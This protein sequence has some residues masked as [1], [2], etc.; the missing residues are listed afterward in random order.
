MAKLC[1]LGEDVEPC[2]EGSTIGPVQFS[3]EDD[4]KNK[5]FSMIEKMQEILS[6][7]GGTTPVLTN[8]A[9][10]I[11]DGLWSAIYEWLW[12]NHH[13]CECDLCIHGIYEDES[14]KFVILRSRKNLTYFRL[15][16]SLTE[17]GGFQAEGDLEPVAPDFKP[18]DSVFAA[19]D[20]EA[21][22]AKFTAEHEE[23]PEEE[24]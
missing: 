12:S 23:K 17:E 21:F 14:Q 7:E 1:I 10:E 9:V 2:F 24:A 19:E 11:G 5:V 18:V 20:V 22:E 15:N 13:E 6:N 3:F 4:F 8:Y 16:F